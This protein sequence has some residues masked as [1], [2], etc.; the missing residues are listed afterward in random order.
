M[1]HQPHSPVQGRKYKSRKERPCD[2]CR[3]RKVCCIREPGDDACSLCR[4][5]SQ[6]CSYDQGPTPRRRRPVTSALPSSNEDAVIVPNT[7]ARATSSAPSPNHESGPRE[8]ASQYV[9]LSG[10]HDPFVLRHANFGPSNYYRSGDWACL[11]LQSSAAI[12]SLF[13][14]SP[15]NDTRPMHYP[16]STLLDA[17]YPLHHELLSTYFEVVHTAFPLLEPARF[18]KGNKIDLC[19]LA[20]MYALARPFC[21]SATDL[22]SE[23]LEAFVTRALP[24]DVRIP[25]LDTIEAALLFLQ[26][27]SPGP[28]VP[29]FHSQIGGLVA[30]C[31]DAG[32][33]VDPT[34]WDIPA[35]D[36]ARRMRIWWAVYTADKWAA[37]GLGRPSFI[38]EDACNVPP[39]TLA[40]IPVTTVG[41]QTLPRT[42]SQMFVAM[43]AL[44]QILATVLN[45]FYTL[46]ATEQMARATPAEIGN[47][48]AYFEQRLFEFRARYLAPLENVADMFLDPTGTVFL[49]FY[50]VES[51]VQ[52]ALLRCVSLNDRL[53]QQIRQQAKQVM[54]SV[55]KLVENLQVTR[56]R[57]FWWS[58]ISKVNFAMAG[59]SMF[60]ML[61]SSTTD[62]EIEYWSSEITRYRRLLEMQSLSFDTTKLAAARMSALAN[63]RSS[64][65]AQGEAGT[66][67]RSDPKQAFCRDFGVEINTL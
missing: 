58:P 66:A 10:D 20:T 32:I 49:A 26:S 23:S 24:L 38:H 7:I 6:I 15:L 1:E 31:H 25:R 37:L 61:L 67:G 63:V 3:R 13:T 21:S 48:K 14:V 28:M 41:E 8:W 46:K 47:L 36:R 56:L 55:V 62:E 44:T 30:M 60:S 40:H 34:H 59:G 18:V 54:I 2:A 11:R 16:P 64:G 42:S 5:Q 22:P 33:N 39:L 4:M 27:D 35:V 45:T 29:G 19:L 9:G 65:R 43:A 17:A 52:R 51:V 53:C 57:A 12:P 50:T